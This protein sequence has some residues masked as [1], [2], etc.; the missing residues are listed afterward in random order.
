MHEDLDQITI[1]GCIAWESWN[2]FHPESIKQLG[3]CR[4]EEG[5]VILFSRDCQ[6]SSTYEAIC[7]DLPVCLRHLVDV[8]GELEG[9]PFL[10]VWLV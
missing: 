5:N 9:D 6:Q 7:V 1:T 3:H 8:S 10:Q 4:S 2:L